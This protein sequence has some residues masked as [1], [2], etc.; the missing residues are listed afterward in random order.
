MTDIPNIDM[1]KLRERIREE[2]V[3][4]IARFES[5]PVYAAQTGGRSLLLLFM[6]RE[7]PSSE[8]F[9]QIA[10]LARQGYVFSA[11]F[12]HTFLEF[13]PAESV[14]SLLPKGTT[15]LGGAKERDLIKIA[16]SSL[17]LIAT[18][19]SLNTAAKLSAGIDDST[20][21]LLITRFLLLGKPVIIGRDLTGLGQSVSALFPN[22]PP[23]FL[24]TAE[25]NFHRVEHLGARFVAPNGV[26]EAVASA[27]QEPLNETPARLAK[28]KPSPKRYFV[29]AEDVWAVK[30]RKQK[31]LIHP[32]D[33]IVTDQAREYA[34]L[35]GITLRPAD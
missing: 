5:S 16:K 25:T 31:E 13:V 29:T 17:G 14:L 8:F 26:A 20:P 9:T 10:S 12:S 24:R 33:A 7:M 11:A 32:R 15:C 30:D 19:L 6:C 22:A 3:A 21:T 18:N 28:S 23:A 1:D 35:Q 34:I 2:V 27:F 4:A